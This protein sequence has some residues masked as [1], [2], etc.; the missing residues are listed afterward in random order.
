M[1]TIE[2]L[3]RIYNNPQL[4]F[5]YLHP[6]FTLHAPGQNPIAGTF[7]GA[8]GMKAHFKKMESMTNNSFVEELTD[9]FLA[10]DSFGMVVHRM[11]AE[12][13]GK[14]L[15]TWG[16]GLW[17]FKDGLIIDHWESVGDQDHWDDFWS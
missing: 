13:N 12:R 6:D 5:E 10:D 9:T 4:V 14:K 2:L 3:K 7:H 15:D 16:F 8:E 17:R 11:T 1:T